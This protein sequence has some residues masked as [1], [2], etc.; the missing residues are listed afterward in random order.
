MKY[1]VLALIIIQSFQGISQCCPYI[2]DV[3]VIPSNPTTSDNIQ[4][5]TTVTTPNL[6]Q[7]ISSGYTQ[8][9]DTI[10]VE[11][12]YYSGMATALQTYYDTLDIGLL[13]AGNYTVYFTAYQSSDTICTY[14]SVNTS[15]FN[16][17]VTGGTTA[18]PP[19]DLQT[20]VLYPNPSAGDFSIQLP[21][22]MSATRVQLF[23]LSGKSIVELPYS[24]KLSVSIAPGT[25]IIRILQNEIVLG[26]QRLIIESNN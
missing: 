6:G 12:C 16:F 22:G 10:F 11:A 24:E 14:D 15:S 3:D 8:S 18:V 21:T 4:V 23:D 5:V 17:S 9:N 1:F 7:F 19:I 20:V 13:P 26:I 25:Y 2:D